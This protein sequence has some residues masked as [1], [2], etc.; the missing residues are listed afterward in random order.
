[1]SSASPVLSPAHPQQQS[2]FP[3]QGSPTH[4]YAALCPPAVA[5]A[6]RR[7]PLLLCLTVLCGEFDMLLAAPVLIRSFELAGF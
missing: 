2:P 7:C 4:R 3:P 5:L 1:M 6:V